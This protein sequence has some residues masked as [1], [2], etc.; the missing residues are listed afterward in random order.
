MTGILPAMTDDGIKVMSINLLLPE[1]HMAVI[2]RGPPIS[3]AVQQFWNKVLWGH[4]I[5]LLVNLPPG[6]SDAAL[7]VMQSLPVNGA[8]AVTTPQELAAMVVRK[9]VD[10]AN[11]LHVPIVGVVENMS[12]FQR[13]DSGKRY[14]IFGPS[15]VEEV[16]A[17]AGTILAKLPVD[18]ELPRLGD[19]GQIAAYTYN[20]ESIDERG[21]AFEAECP[22]PQRDLR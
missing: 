15:H 9:A 11:Q 10:M 8:V 18:P 16:A 3:K 20:S 14:K 22:L 17:A 21:K 7:S 6:T 2:W 12:Y 19:E 13:P 4:L 1:E 5:Y